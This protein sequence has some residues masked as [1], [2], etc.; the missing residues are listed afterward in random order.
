MSKVSLNGKKI[1]TKP[2]MTNVTLGLPLSQAE[3]LDTYQEQSGFQRGKD[4]SPKSH[5]KGMISGV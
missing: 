4:P 1:E 3:E 5:T 2:A